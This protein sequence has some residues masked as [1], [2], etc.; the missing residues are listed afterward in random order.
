MRSDNS[1]ARPWQWNWFLSLDKPDLQSVTK[2]KIQL[3]NSSIHDF[4]LQTL[5]ALDLKYQQ[6][7]SEGNLHLALE[8]QTKALMQSR[9]LV[10]T[11]YRGRTETAVTSNPAGTPE[12]GSSSMSIQSCILVF[13]GPRGTEIISA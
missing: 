9:G 3:Q 13:R 7:I 12:S 11:R 6:P 10:E 5:L 2:T 4:L 8:S 1:K